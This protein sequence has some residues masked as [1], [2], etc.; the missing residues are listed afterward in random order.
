[1]NLFACTTRCYKDAEQRFTQGGDSI[2][3]FKGAVDAGFGNSKTTS[4]I[5]FNLWGKR[6][7]SL[8]PYLKDKTQV[9]V[10]VLPERDMVATTSVAVFLIEH[11][12][13]HG[14]SYLGLQILLIPHLHTA[15]KATMYRC[16]GPFTEQTHFLTVPAP[17]YLTSWRWL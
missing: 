7:D 13:G 4:W 14:H 9:A 10:S 8:L 15:R 2:V 3:T 17:R 11:G 16:N 6:G 1:M 5:K 12:D